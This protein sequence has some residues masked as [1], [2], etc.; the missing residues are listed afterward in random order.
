[1]MPSPSSAQRP[2]WIMIA[3]PYTS[4]GA[5]AAAREENLRRLNRAALAVFEAGHVPIVGV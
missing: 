5:D 3:G 2:L 4:G 1:M